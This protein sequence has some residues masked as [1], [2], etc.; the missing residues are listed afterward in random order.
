MCM[1]DDR[2]KNQLKLVRLV[3]YLQ[4][5]RFNIL[6]DVRNRKIPLTVTFSKIPYIFINTFGI[7]ISF[8]CCVTITI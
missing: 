3:I 4:V 6:I 2:L 5:A 7:V 8:E 1:L